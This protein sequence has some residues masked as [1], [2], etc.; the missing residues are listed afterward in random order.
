[1]TRKA[2]I[3]PRLVISSS[4]IPSAKYSCSGSL[5]R[6]S[7]GRTAMDW[8]LG[9]GTASRALNGVKTRP[10]RPA[11]LRAKS[12]ATTA[13]TKPLADATAQPFVGAIPESPF[14]AASS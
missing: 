8:I 13:T 2:L 1:M 14:R 3:L 4:V 7:N 10:R 12:T 11:T 6:L 5:E 9:R